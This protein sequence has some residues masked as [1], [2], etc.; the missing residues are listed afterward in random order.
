MQHATS[1]DGT[2]IAYWTTGSGPPL[3]LVHGT[4]ASHQRWDGITPRLAEHLTV[5]TMDRRGRGES[6]DGPT[7]SLQRE[8]E[9]IAAVTEAVGGPV[10]VLGHS[11]GAT[12]ALEAALVTDQIGRLLLYEPPMQIDQ[13]P[14][15]L[16]IPDR[17]QAL[18]DQ[19]ALEPA[20]EL[21]MREVARMPEQELAVYRTLPMWPV[22]VALAP[23]IPRELRLPSVAPPTPERYAR[24]ELPVL[25]MTGGDSPPFYRTAIDALHAT[26]PDSRVV[27][28]AGQQHIAMDLAPDAFVR[29][30]LDFVQT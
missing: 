20:L 28:F 17:M 12:C 27:T 16:E 14:V 26:L 29:A 4:T 24:L 3:L 2:P 5:I 11:Y 30:V 9:D 13:P 22:R 15:P 1:R 10:T 18:I 23:T 21:M 6:G 8:G 7:Y 25:L 19:G